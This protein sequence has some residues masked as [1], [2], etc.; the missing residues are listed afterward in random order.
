MAP[1]PNVGKFDPGSRGVYAACYSGAISVFRPD[2]ANHYW[3]IEDFPVHKKV[4]SLAVDPEPTL[5]TSLRIG[6]AVIRRPGWWFV[7]PR[8]RDDKLLNCK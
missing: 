8:R 3:E 6:R 5:S 2:D 1:D 4:H 7:N